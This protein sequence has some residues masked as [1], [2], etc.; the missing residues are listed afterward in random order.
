M[1]LT[2]HDIE[3]IEAWLRFGTVCFVIFAWF[4]LLTLGWKGI[5]VFIF[6]GLGG[7]IALSKIWWLMIPLFFVAIFSIHFVDKYDRE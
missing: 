6:F 2:P 4:Y 1:M 7:L 3:V 5:V